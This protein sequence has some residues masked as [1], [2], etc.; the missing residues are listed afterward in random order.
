MNNTVNNKIIASLSHGIQKSNP[1]TP[2]EKQCSSI[3]KGLRS[4]GLNLNKKR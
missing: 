2:L 3:G 1:I 4:G